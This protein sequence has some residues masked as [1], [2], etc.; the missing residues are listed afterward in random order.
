MSRPLQTLKLL[1]DL[2]PHTVTSA[3]RAAGLGH[4]TIGRWL[5]GQRTPRYEDLEA[6]LGLFGFTLTATRIE[7]PEKPN[8]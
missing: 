6:A 1:I 5:S 3:S 2:S 4:G 8:D 7:N